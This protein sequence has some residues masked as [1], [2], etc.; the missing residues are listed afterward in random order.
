MYLS[1]EKKKLKDSVPNCKTFMKA[2]MTL[3]DIT[4][5]IRHIYV[6]P[7]VPLCFLVFTFGNMICVYV[8]YLHMSLIFVFMCVLQ[9]CFII[10]RE[11][12]I[13]F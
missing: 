1:W 10:C 5:F 13:D 3:L 4:G 11:S 8:D 2:F 6:P 9:L 12:V 7:K